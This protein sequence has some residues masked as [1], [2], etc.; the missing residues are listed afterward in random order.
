M[1]YL[2]SWRLPTFAAAT[3]LAG[4]AAHS[5]PP[6]PARCLQP[7]SPPARLMEPPYTDGSPKD[8]RVVET[9]IGRIGVLI[10]AD[11]F[12]EQYVKAAGERK[13]DLQ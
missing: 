1:D 13:P 6:E 3:L 10:C 11:T 8:I 5:V 2:K 7:V 4:C 12:V 9:A